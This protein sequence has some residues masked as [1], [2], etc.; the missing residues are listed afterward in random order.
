MIKMKL[1]FRKAIGQDKGHLSLQL[2]KKNPR[3]RRWQALATAKTSL[4]K[5]MLSSKER[6]DVKRGGL[7]THNQEKK[8]LKIFQNAQN[9]KV[10][11]LDNNFKGQDANKLNYKGENWMIRDWRFFKHSKL[12]EEKP[13]QYKLYYDNRFWVT[14]DSI[15]LSNQVY[16]QRKKNVVKAMGQDKSKLALFP[17]KKQPKVR[18]WQQTDPLRRKLAIERTDLTMRTETKQKEEKIKEEILIEMLKDLISDPSVDDRKLVY[19]YAK[20]YS[21][22]RMELYFAFCAAQRNIELNVRAQRDQIA[23]VIP[24]KKKAGMLIGKLSK[25]LVPA[26][27]GLVLKPSKQNPKVHRW[28]KIA[29]QLFNPETAPKI[30]YRGPITPEEKALSLWIKEKGHGEIRWFTHKT[31]K[32]SSIVRLPNGKILND[33]GTNIKTIKEIVSYQS[34]RGGG[35]RLK[36]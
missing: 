16:L 32:G 33:L 31:G 26:R 14:F 18:R 34:E 20:K 27:T 22:N 19:E 6:T 15:D 24:E 10:Y 35:I 36:L 12:T 25:A 3:V 8:A 13:G 21:L 2:S 28:Q 4:P 5:E 29:Y 1:G 30:K 9:I 23:K 7:I 11:T 17:S